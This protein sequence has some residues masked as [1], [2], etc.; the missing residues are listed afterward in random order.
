MSEEKAEWQKNVGQKDRN[1]KFE[2][3]VGVRPG[4]TDKLLIA[5]FFAQHFFANRFM[6]IPRPEIRPA[7]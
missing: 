2:I 3:G 4:M 7:P 1:E 6:P 5:N